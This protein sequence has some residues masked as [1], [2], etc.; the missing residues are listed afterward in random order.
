M[1]QIPN[2]LNPKSSNKRHTNYLQYAKGLNYGHETSKKAE[3]E[4]W[5][6]ARYIQTIRVESI[7]V[8]T[9]TM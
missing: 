5:K 3:R 1:N 9:N 6:E 2:L 8:F 7:L 4:L